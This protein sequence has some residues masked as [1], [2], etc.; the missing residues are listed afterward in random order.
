MACLSNYLENKLIDFLF[1]A[2]TF[3]PPAT[4]YVA[5][6]TA[7]PTAGGGGTEV[8]GGSYARVG[9]TGST[10]NFAATNAPGSTAS[11]SSGTSGAT[12]NNGTAT[13]PTPSGNWGTVTSVGLYDASSAGNLLFFG[14]LASSQ[15]VNSGNP[16]NFAAAALAVT[17]T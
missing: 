6:F 1:R 13:F 11:T 12:S 4:I 14:N 5:L 10:A 8:S 17:L 3:T 15:V 9:I 2:G 16:F 7:A